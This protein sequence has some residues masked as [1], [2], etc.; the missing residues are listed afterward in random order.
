M[1]RQFYKTIIASL[2]LAGT[3]QIVSADQPFAKEMFDERSPIVDFEVNK[4][5]QYRDVNITVTG[6]RDF[7][8]RQEYS[9]GAL[10]LQTNELDD[11][12]YNYEIV[13]VT[14]NKIP[15]RKDRLDNGRGEK[16]RDYVYESVTQS[17]N[18]RIQNGKIVVFDQD[19]SEANLEPKK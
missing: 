11:G 5:E 17:G 2:L 4:I 10:D 12:N 13:A 3:S 8:K 7:S 19:V 15:L 1:Q 9:K 6:P 16:E 14:S 18:F